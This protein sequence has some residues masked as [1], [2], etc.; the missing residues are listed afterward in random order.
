MIAD[1]FRM[2]KVRQA[3]M[4][5]T[6]AKSEDFSELE[7]GIKLRE[8]RRELK[9]TMQYVAEAAGLSVGF[10]SQIER[11][12]S[13]PS[14]SSLAAISK[15][16]QLPVAYFLEQPG[17]DRPVTRK[18][19]RETFQT[20]AKALR[21]ERLSTELEGGAIRALI[22]HEPPG[23]RAEQISHDGEELFFVLKGSLIVE[24]EDETVVLREGDSVH[25]DSK[26]RHSSWNYT[27]DPCSYMHV[28][29]LD[30]FDEDTDLI[31]NSKRL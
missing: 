12:F 31:K 17:G 4:Q 29:T 8:R 27:S 18:D 21:Y 23:H 13:S 25:F 20:G 11:G 7:L 1:M 24:I 28:C 26:R 30:V 14:L 2:S 6:T 15:I 9:L 5:E 3:I 22:V 16:L 10:I 19:T